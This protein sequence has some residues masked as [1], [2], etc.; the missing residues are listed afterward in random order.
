V[1]SRGIRSPYNPLHESF[2]RAACRLGYAIVSA[3]AVGA[4]AIGH[5]A[6]LTAAGQTTCVMPCALDRPF[7][8]ENKG[9]WEEVLNYSGAS[10]MSEFAF[11]TAAS[12]LNL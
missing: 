4:D 8:P 7:P 12:V 3:F 5:R 11:G 6:A 10:A 1:G 9:L 2:A